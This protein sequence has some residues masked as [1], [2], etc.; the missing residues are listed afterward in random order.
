M[1]KKLFVVFVIV[2]GVAMAMPSHASKPVMVRMVTSLG[3]VDLQLYPDKAPVTVKNFLSYVNKGS[4]NGTVFHR[5]IKG[6]MIQGGGFDQNLA[7]R[8]TQDP[9]PN[10]ADN[11]LK[12]VA[13]TIAMARTG[14]P[15]S[16]TNQFFINTVDNSFLDFKNKSVQGWGYA[17]FGKVVKGMNVV[18]KIENT[19]TGFRGPFPNFPSPVIVI[20]KM[21]RLK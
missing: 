15:D 6:F 8:P 12:N 21:E 5:V 20:L 13:G 7:R 16:A 14:I 19:P 10:E 18:Q 1:F 11:G 3:N 2:F 9:I 17:V 4:Y